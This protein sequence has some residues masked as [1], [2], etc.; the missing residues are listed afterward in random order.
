[1]LSLLSIEAILF[2]LGNVKHCVIFL[3]DIFTKVSRYMYFK[4]SIGLPVFLVQ[5]A[6]SA[7]RFARVILNFIIT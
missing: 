3:R 7:T 6:L 5:F 1:M 4:I 2:S